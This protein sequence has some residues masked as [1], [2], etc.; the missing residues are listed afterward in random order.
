MSNT[1]L[2]KCRNLYGPNKQNLGLYDT[3]KKDVFNKLRTSENDD[4]HIK[5]FFSIAKQAR[6]KFNI[7]NSRSINNGK[8]KDTNTLKTSNTNN[9]LSSSGPI[10]EAVQN[11]IN[12][13]KLSYALECGAFLID[14]MYDGKMA[15]KAIT[16]NEY[17]NL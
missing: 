9:R 1:S 3:V 7:I 13:K 2:L 8:S 12:M 10:K 14:D 6:E 11:Y 5:L 4:A 15:S 16:I 17:N